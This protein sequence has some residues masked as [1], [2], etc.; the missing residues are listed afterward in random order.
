[1]WK[2]KP[3]KQMEFRKSK[4]AHEQ[5][6]QQENSRKKLTI[7]LLISV[8]DFCHAGIWTVLNMDLPEHLISP[9]RNIYSEQ[10]RTALT[11]ENLWFKREGSERRCM[12]SHIFNICSKYILST[13]MLKS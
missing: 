5:N 13:T 8:R 10:K 6:E 1:M 7:V 11:V 12:L 9:L 2:E 4:G 3:N